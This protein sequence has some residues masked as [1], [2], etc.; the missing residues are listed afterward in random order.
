MIKLHHSVFTAA[1]LISASSINS[2][3]SMDKDLE[4][5]NQHQP[6]ENQFKLIHIDI[7]KDAV[8]KQSVI[9]LL[10]ND[11][12]SMLQ[13]FGLDIN[14]DEYQYTQTRQN[15][16]L[17]LAEI[18]KIMSFLKKESSKFTKSELEI[19][20]K[21]F[22]DFEK[23]EIIINQLTNPLHA[24]P[25][26]RSGNKRIPPAGVKEKIGGYLDSKDLESTYNSIPDFKAEEKLREKLKLN[27]ILSEEEYEELQSLGEKNLKTK[28]TFEKIKQKDMVRIT[29][30]KNISESVENLVKNHGSVV[31]I[32][33]TLSYREHFPKIESLV[34]VIKNNELNII[35]IN[36]MCNEIDSILEA[37][38]NNTT[39][40]ILNLSFNDMTYN[41]DIKYSQQ[42]YSLFIQNLSLET[43]ILDRCQIGNYQI[44]PIVKVL[45]N[46]K[47]IK[48]LSLASNSIRGKRG[49]DELAPLFQNNPSLEVL[50]LNNNHILDEG[51]I[52]LSKLL[53]ENN[54]LK[55][56][57]LKGNKISEKGKEALSALKHIKIEI[58]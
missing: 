45:K 31:P 29:I 1:L 53:Q 25:F 52:E 5:N 16:N 49:V 32:N 13:P 39:I 46:S 28:E 27:G 24:H 41:N 43:L 40:K 15:P 12:A 17:L 34:R 26:S 9:A 38:E 4:I 37:M 55:V 11:Y 51:A 58:D 56:I 48:V 2:S 20:Q 7:P 36:L 54:N 33:L 14:I 21:I 42:L 57:N 47:T 50:I 22:Q 6:S 10:V 8:L 30:E 44:D 35:Q 18:R 3:F 19:T 23:L